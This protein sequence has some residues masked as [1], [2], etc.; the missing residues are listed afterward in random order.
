MDREWYYV[1]KRYYPEISRFFLTLTIPS[2]FKPLEAKS[3]YLKCI[4]RTNPTLILQNDGL[5]FYTETLT[6]GFVI[7]VKFSLPLTFPNVP[8]P[9]VSPRT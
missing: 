5:V 8:I 2:N 9:R 6:A 1:I 7:F 3:H 4:A